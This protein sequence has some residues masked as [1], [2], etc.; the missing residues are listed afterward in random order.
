[1]QEEV[2]QDQ[3]TLRSQPRRG[4]VYSARGFSPAFTRLPATSAC[5]ALS[6]IPEETPASTQTP[7]RNQTDPAD[8]Q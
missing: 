5:H 1:M 6:G 2:P 4:F 7:E 8:V 3:A